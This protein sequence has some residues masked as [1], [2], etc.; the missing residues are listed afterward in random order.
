[1]ILAFISWKFVELPFRNG[2]ILNS[3]VI[4]TALLILLFQF[5]LGLILSNNFQKNELARSGDDSINV[6]EKFRGIHF[7]GKNCSFPFIT[8]QPCIIT[9]TS[10]KNRTIVIIGDSHARILSGAL[11]E[12]VGLYSELIDLTASGC[13]FLI[14]MSIRHGKSFTECN[15]E[16]QQRRLK[17]VESL[18]FQNLIFILYSRTASYYHEHHFKNNFGYKERGKKY[19]AEMPQ[20]PKHERRRHFEASLKKTLEKLKAKGKLIYVLDGPENGW[21]PV[22]IVRLKGSHFS[23]N[24]IIKL[25][26]L[27]RATSEKWREPILQ[28][29]DGLVREVDHRPI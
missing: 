29:A 17:Y 9:G 20:Q 25:L 2:K 5:C 16:Y 13:P 23:K 8:H 7:E 10:E 4:P 15:Q 3:N 22:E 11:Y 18:N 12:R 1:M 28:I 27:E 14:D 6:E 19:I 21:D 24:E 26:T